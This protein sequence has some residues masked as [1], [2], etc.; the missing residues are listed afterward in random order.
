MC[1]DFCRSVAHSNYDWSIIW[2]RVCGDR[3]IFKLLRGYRKRNCVNYIVINKAGVTVSALR[4]GKLLTERGHHVIFIGARSK[5]HKNHNYHDGIK[6]YRYRSLPIPKS[7]GWYS[8]FPTIKELKKVFRKENIDIVHMFLPMSGAIVAI[9][10]ARSLNIKTV[11]HSHSQPEN[12][13]MSMPRLI[14]PA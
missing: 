7:G 14:R 3:K 4:F 2:T 13:F 1:T 9:K 11:A 5:E 12:L 8:A 6:I 10:A